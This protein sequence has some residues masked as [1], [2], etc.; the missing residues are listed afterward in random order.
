MRILFA[1]AISMIFSLAQA[2]DPQILKTKPIE[3]AVY[4]SGAVVSHKAEFDLKPGLNLLHLQGFPEHI[5]LNS[6]QIEATPHYAITGVRHEINRASDG[7]SPLGR[8]KR[9]SLEQAKYDLMSKVITREALEAELKM[10]QA[11]QQIGGEDAALSAEALEKMANFVRKR[12]ADTRKLALDISREEARINER[13][14]RLERDLA[15]MRSRELSARRDIVIEVQA[16]KALRSSIEVRYFSNRAGWVAHHDLRSEGTDKPLDIVTRARVQQGTGIDWKDVQLTLLTGTPHLGGAPPELQRWY[17]YLNDPASMM[18][19]ERRYDA[20]MGA[21]PAR[22]QAEQHEMIV[23]DFEIAEPAFAE[24]R[25]TM[26]STFALNLPYSISG[27]N[28]EY[29]LELR[30]TS[31]PASYR[32][33]ATPKYGSDVFLTAELV[34]W[35]QYNLLPGEATVYFE[36]NMVGRSYLDL[37]SADDTLRI[38]MGRDPNVKVSYALAKDYSATRSFGSKRKLSRGYNIEVMNNGPKAIQLRVADH[39]PLTSNSEIEVEVDGL[40]GGKLDTNT[41]FITWELQ[42]EP[43]MRKELAL[44]YTVAYPKKMVLT[45]M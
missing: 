37:S 5:D 28:H 16:R 7:L 29:T 4:Q 2:Q 44:R 3:A 8:A 40:D 12:V 23:D 10:I 22:A 36:N 45:G 27:D 35:D 26:Q 24:M 6:L 25:Q 13:I 34:D 14:K 39:V 19:K 32:H 9:D 15:D 38:S 17:L 1:L 11:N 18:Q 21:M 33:R 43:G 42:L 31:I 30:S 20:S 41:G